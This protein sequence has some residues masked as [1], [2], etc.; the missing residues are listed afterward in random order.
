MASASSSSNA[1]VPCP[2]SGAIS[3][4]RTAVTRNPWA[5]VSAP[6]TT[7]AATSPIE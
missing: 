5:G 4:D 1:I 2:D 6:A 7:A 3:L